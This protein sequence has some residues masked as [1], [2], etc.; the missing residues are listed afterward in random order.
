M[1]VFEA[2]RVAEITHDSIPAG[3]VVSQNP[4]PESEVAKGSAV[5]LLVSR[6]GEAEE[7]NL[8]VPDPDCASRSQKITAKSNLTVGSVEEKR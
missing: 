5:S 2:R 6:E 7:F 4:P 1:K 8:V 3:Y